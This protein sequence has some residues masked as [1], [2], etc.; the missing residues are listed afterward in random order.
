MVLPSVGQFFFEINYLLPPFGCLWTGPY[1]TGD[2]FSPLSP[3]GE[4]PPI[5]FL[6]F[7]IRAVVFKRLN[8]TQQALCSCVR[9][10]LGS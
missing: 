2:F 5:F 10:L 6:L 1:K 8:L 7:F 4:N 3:G 9:D